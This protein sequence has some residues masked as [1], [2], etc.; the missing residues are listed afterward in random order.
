MVRYLN[1]KLK[2]S[3]SNKWKAVVDF[4]AFKW[5]DIQS[6]VKGINGL[7]ERY[8]YIS[9]DS[10]YNNSLEKVKLPVKEENFDIEAEC[11]RLRK[12]QKKNDKYGYV[13]FGFMT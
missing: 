2:I 4:S 12:V 7:A 13:T 9:S 10:I 1:E 8:I 5:R 6:V 11:L 3:E